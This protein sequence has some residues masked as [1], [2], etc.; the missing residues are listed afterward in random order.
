[1]IT[2]LTGP[3]HSGKTT[4]LKEVVQ[5]LKARGVRPAGFLSVASCD[6][7]EP[8]GYDLLDVGDGGTTPFIRP[9]GEPEWQQI[10]RG[11][12]HFLLPGGLAAAE[13]KIIDWQGADLFVVDEVGPLE[14]TGCGLWPALKKVLFPPAIEYVLVAREKILD[15]LKR[16][17]EAERLA[18]TVLDVRDRAASR[19]AI[20]EI[21]TRSRRRK[22]NRK[23]P[24]SDGQ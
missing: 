17:L 6:G 14:L 13:K 19:R 1:M 4:F 12:R 5:S 9:T 24:E 2:I 20:E 3:V 11:R 10:G 8:A 18:V 16:R 21:A 22:K 7:R 23:R 15:D